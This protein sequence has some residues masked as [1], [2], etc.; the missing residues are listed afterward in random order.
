MK[1]NSTYQQQD[2]IFTT[3]R[4]TPV[5]N[6]ELDLISIEDESALVIPPVFKKKRKKI[7]QELNDTIID[8]AYFNQDLKGIPIRNVNVK[9]KYNSETQK[10]IVAFE[11]QVNNTINT[12]WQTLL[13]IVA[14]GILG[15]IKAFSSARFNQV[16]KSLF[17]HHTA[18]EVVREEKV[19]FHRANL[20]LFVIFTISALLLVDC[21]VTNNSFSLSIEFSYIKTIL[22]IIAAYIIKFI[23]GNILFN[24]FSRADLSKV[25]TYNTLIYNYLFGIALLP[26]LAFIYFSNVSFDFV[27]NYA[28]IP[29]IIFTFLFRTFRLFV[30]GLQN[31]FFVLYII[32]YICTLEILPL[33]VLS[34]IFIFK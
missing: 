1:K 7:Q 10:E 13:L 15:F 6:G 8:T 28:V 5:T 20:G 14:L 19:F 16:I 24:F 4:D 25:Y 17:S 32:L 12:T 9:K 23:S 31:N 34:K 29:I 21:I 18:E 33:V 27:F 3:D 11:P 30:F 26:C 22:F 2:S